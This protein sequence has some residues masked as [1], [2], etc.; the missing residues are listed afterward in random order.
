MLSWN[1][2]LSSEGGTGESVLGQ[3]GTWYTG[4][5]QQFKDSANGVQTIYSFKQ[6]T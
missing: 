2:R 1:T 4:T 3:P 5:Q 6:S